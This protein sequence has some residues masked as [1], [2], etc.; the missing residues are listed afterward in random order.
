MEITVDFFI[1]LEAEEKS[2]VDKDA[3]K[4]FISGV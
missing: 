2:N 1:E 4:D 3:E